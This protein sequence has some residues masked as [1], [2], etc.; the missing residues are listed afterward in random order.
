MV[1]MSNTRL[2]IY[3]RVYTLICIDMKRGWTDIHTGLIFTIQQGDCEGQIWSMYSV[4][5][6][7]GLAPQASYYD[8]PIT[9]GNY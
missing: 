3:R 4:L 2:I 6:S 7:G 8:K 9:Y 5:G 1:H